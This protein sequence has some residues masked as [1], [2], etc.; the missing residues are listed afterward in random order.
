M[1]CDPHPLRMT[2]GWKTLTLNLIV[3]LLF[4]IPLTVTALEARAN[5][6]LLC[7]INETLTRKVILII[8]TIVTVYSGIREF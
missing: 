8:I 1:F 7:G 2:F 3:Y 6:K 4:V 5:E